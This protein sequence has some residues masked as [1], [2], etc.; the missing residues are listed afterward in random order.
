MKSNH[1]TDGLISWKSPSNLAIIKYWGK[2]GR[3]L[4]RNP[5]ISFTLSKAHT[6]TTLAYKKKI[7]SAEKNIEIDFLFEGDRNQAFAARIE[8]FLSSVEDVLPFV[9]D[10]AFQIESRNTFPHSSGIASSASAMS[11]L[12]LCMMSMKYALEGK[13]EEASVEFLREA[14]L[15]SRLGSG[16]ACRSMFPYM[17]VW[18]AHKDVA[19]SS[20]DFGVAYADVHEVFKTF[21]DDILIVSKEEK[22]VS[23]SAGH[24]LMEGNVFSGPRYA[25]AHDRM[26]TLLSALQT[27]DLERF[28]TIAENEALTLHALMMCSE[29]SYI[30]MRP[31]TLHIIEE[32]RRY[33]TETKHP[34][35]FSLDA[36]PNIHLLYPAEI[37]EQIIQ[38]TNDTLKKYC[39][40]NIVIPDVVGKGAT[41]LG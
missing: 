32:I 12:S 20:D 10:Y 16:S 4:P 30:L 21:H 11:A 6:V 19:G 26:S 13:N 22:S 7:S 23:S 36:G 1:H 40:N 2:Y 3:Q 38:F 31:G 24:K 5:S 37:K 14:S 15:L 17:G 39:Q 18:G 41:R 29:P 8:K 33:R 28:G 34:V 25:Q 27:G 35:Y 9:R